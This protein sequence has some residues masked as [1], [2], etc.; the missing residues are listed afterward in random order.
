MQLTAYLTLA[1]TLLASTMTPVSA[2]DTV[3]LNVVVPA[4]SGNGTC[5]TKPVTGLDFSVVSKAPLMGVFA[6]SKAAYD[7]MLPSNLTDEETAN[8]PAP[9]FE[10]SCYTPPDELTTCTKQMPTDRTIDP[11]VMCILLKNAHNVSTTSVLN[12]TWLY[13]GEASP[14]SP[15]NSGNKGGNGSGSAPNSSASSVVA[16]VAPLAI[17]GALL[18]MVSSF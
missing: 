5:S 6:A 15:S 3:S 10:M 17:G 14:N 11:Q 16:S 2:A 7:A 9:L 1:A 8:M 18:A 4:H 13:N 12:V